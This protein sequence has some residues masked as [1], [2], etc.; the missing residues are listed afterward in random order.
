MLRLGSSLVACLVICACAQAVAAQ[1]STPRKVDEYGNICC[2]DEKARLD[3]FA[4][5]LASE[6]DARAYIIYYGGR[7]RNYPY[8]HSERVGL[9]KRGDAAA[10][11]RKLKPFL[12]STRGVDP[13]RILVVN[14]GY[15]EHWTAELWVVPQGAAPPRPTPTVDPRKVRFRKGR[16]NR[17][18]Y[19]WDGC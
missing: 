11:V 17:R 4:A 3:N 14:G 19:A 16:V 8:C 2:D 13:A 1:A 10:R 15:R 5:V 12:I 18:D 7:R 6:P 9:P